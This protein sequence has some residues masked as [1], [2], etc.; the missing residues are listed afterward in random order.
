MPNSLRDFRAYSNNIPS[1]G[2][3]QI[4]ADFVA[5]GRS[6]GTLNIG[7]AGNGAPTGQGLIDKA[8][9]T[10]RSWTVTTN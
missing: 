3:N 4:L 7:S 5:A 10:G 2:I 1:S 6:S 8:T 9:L